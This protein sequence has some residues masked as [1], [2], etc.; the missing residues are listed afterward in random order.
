MG[1]GIELCFNDLE[2][3]LSHVLWEVV[4]IADMG[5]SE[6]GSGFGGR[7]GAEEGGLEVFY[8]AGEASKGGSI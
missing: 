5:I 2:F 6:P 7:V 8:K 1:S 4:N 3:E